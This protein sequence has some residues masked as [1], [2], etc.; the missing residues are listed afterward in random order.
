MVLEWYSLSPDLN[1]ETTPSTV[2]WL[3]EHFRRQPGVFRSDHYSSFPGEDG[4]PTTDC[5][6]TLG[7]LVRDTEGIGVGSMVAFMPD[8]VRTSS[9]SGPVTALIPAIVNFGVSLP[10]MRAAARRA[11]EAGPR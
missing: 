5:W 10:V 8:S 6:T 1:P 7:G 9:R 3:T 2:G 11:P 4:L